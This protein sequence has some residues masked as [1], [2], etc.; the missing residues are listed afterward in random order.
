MARKD[1]STATR[2]SEVIREGSAREERHLDDESLSDRDFELTSLVPAGREVKGK[3]KERRES[4][5]KGSA[6][7]KPRCDSRNRLV[8]QGSEVSRGS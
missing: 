8:A 2:V 3:G 6:E 5:G 1:I 7:V 4:S